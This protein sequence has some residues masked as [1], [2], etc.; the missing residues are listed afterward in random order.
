LAS[1]YITLVRVLR[2]TN[3]SIGEYVFPSSHGPT[4]VATIIE[5][6]FVTIKQLL[7]AEKVRKKVYIGLY[8]KLIV[9]SN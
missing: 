7:L 3:N 5:A 1:T 8:K 9:E 2:S 4:T 6:T